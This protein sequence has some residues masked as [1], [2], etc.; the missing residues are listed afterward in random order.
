MCWS[1]LGLKLGRTV[2]IVPTFRNLDDLKNYF[3]NNSTNVPL[4]NGRDI[5]QIIKQEANKLRDFVR[6]E[7]LLYYE[8]YEPKEYVRTEGL[9]NSLRVDAVKNE[10]DALSVR[11][12]FAEAAT[13]P[14]VLGEGQDAGFTPIL[15][16]QGWHVKRG[17]HKDIPHFGFQKGSHFIRNAV[18]KYN[19]DNKYG[20]KIAA[21][22]KSPDGE[23]IEEF[24]S[25]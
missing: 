11:I 18:K 10:G 20:F 25:G 24:M 19:R 22:Y 12:W 5:E 4:A 7:I 2:G 3:N 8:S 13:H 17:W 14:S 23:W 16:D 6:Q 15:I 9:L 1:F 21:Y